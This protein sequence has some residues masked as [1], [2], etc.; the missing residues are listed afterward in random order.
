MDVI[1]QSSHKYSNPD[2]RFGYGI[3]NFKKAFSALV[4]A[5]FQGALV[6]DGCA[7]TLNW[8]G[9]DNS[10]MYYQIERRTDTDTGY[11]KIATINGKTAAF[12]LNSYSY[13]DTV[14]SFSL[15]QAVYRIKEVLADTSLLLLSAANTITAPCFSL[16]NEFTVSPNPFRSVLYLNVNTSYPIQHMGIDLTDMKGNT[17]YQYQGTT[18]SGKFNLSIPAA[19]LAAGVY[20]LTVKD[21]KKILYRKKLLR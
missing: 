11:I 16:L 3:P 18:A 19:R 13:T 5:R 12:Q 15:G 4:T 2:D 1:Q 6:A 7:A 20:V 14:K 9:K 8:T 10:T 17:V 21:G